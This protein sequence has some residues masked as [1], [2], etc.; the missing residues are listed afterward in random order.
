MG[1][2][3]I[4]KP[5]PAVDSSGGGS[6]PPDDHFLETW[7]SLAP[8]G[9]DLRISQ[10]PGHYLCDF[11]YYTSMSL[12]MQAGQDRNVL[13]FHVPGAAEDADVERGRKIALALIKAMVTCWI[14]EK[15]PA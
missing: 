6:Y 14:D 4:L 9:L 2:P 15:R 10:D 13:F 3:P 5:G 8:A 11:M 1:L 7:K 12:A